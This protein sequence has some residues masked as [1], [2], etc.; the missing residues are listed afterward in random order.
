MNTLGS[1]QSPGP[2]PIGVWSADRLPESITVLRLIPQ[3]A[4]VCR[5]GSL[6]P[7]DRGYAGSRPSL[8]PDPL[9]IG[10]IF[11]LRF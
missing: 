10:I 6:D 7:S 11:L 8:F 9:S 3:G 4:S 2:I 5:L 1:R